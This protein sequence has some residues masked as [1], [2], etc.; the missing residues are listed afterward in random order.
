MFIEIDTAS[1][2]PIYTQ[3]MKELKKSIVKNEWQ[4]DEMLPSIR[5]LAGD[6][7]V[8][9]HTV[10]KAYNLLVDEEVLVKN[11]KGYSLNPA[12]E[13]SID[14]TEQLKLKLEEL[15]VD[16]YIHDI[17]VDEVKDWTKTIA[18]DLKR[19]W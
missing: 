11:Q 7:G 2:V 15:L 17:S 18:K 6:L 9:M 3:L 10:N 8:N 4:P 1:S 12:Q 5:S 16:V 13:V 19:E 14:L